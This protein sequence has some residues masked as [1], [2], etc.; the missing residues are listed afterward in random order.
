MK[1]P[2]GDQSKFQGKWKVESIK[3]G[4]NDLLAGLGQAAGQQGFDMTIEFA[5]DQFRASANI[6]GTAQTSKQEL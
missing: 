1:E 5:G 2:E 6:G 3:V 4:G